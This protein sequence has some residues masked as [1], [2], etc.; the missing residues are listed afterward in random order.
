MYVLY[1]CFICMRM[2]MCMCMRRPGRGDQAG[3]EGSYVYVYVYAYAYAYADPLYRSCIVFCTVFASNPQ[4]KNL[5][6]SDDL[7]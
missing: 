4:V 6:G 2:C 1:V 3:A 7:S 5:L